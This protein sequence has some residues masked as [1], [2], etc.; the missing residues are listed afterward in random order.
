MTRLHNLTIDALKRGYAKAGALYPNIPSLSHWRAWECAAYEDFRLDGRVLDVGCGDGRYFEAVWPDNK[1]VTGVELD[2]GVADAGMRSGVYAGIHVTSADRIP[3]PDASF[4]AVFANCSLEHMDNLEGVIRELNRCLKPGGTLVCSVVTD[5]F[6][7]WN[8]GPHL[9]SRMGEQGLS[10]RLQQDFEDFHHLR[11]PLPAAEWV[12]R[13]EAAGFA[14]ET[15]RPILPKMSS[16]VFLALDT[17]WHLPDSESGGE[18]GARMHA[19]F[20]SRHAFAQGFGK[21]VEAL[22][23]M[24]LDPSECSGAVF[25]FVKPKVDSNGP[26]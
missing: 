25:G 3:E 22:F 2:P 11:N 16:I 18:I 24:E 20:E 4:D 23:E 10:R 12:A 5:K 15:H 19:F 1:N 21:I 17:L 6:I 13:F 26:E 7:E 8:M 14:L 9:L